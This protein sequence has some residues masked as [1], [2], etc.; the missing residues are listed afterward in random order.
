MRYTGN[1]AF[2]EC[3][4]WQKLGGRLQPLCIR[5]HRSLFAI[6]SYP[7]RESMAPY[8][9]SV[10]SVPDIRWTQSSIKLVVKLILCRIFDCSFVWPLPISYCFMHCQLILLLLNFLDVFYLVKNFEFYKAP[11]GLVTIYF[12][13]TPSFIL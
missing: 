13:T 1:T 12:L 5:S 6:S 7:S 9:Q 11:R 2:S 8:S 3:V 4:S 10:G